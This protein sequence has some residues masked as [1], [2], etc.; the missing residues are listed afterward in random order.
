MDKNIFS[1][2]D[3]FG[4]KDIEDIKIYSSDDEEKEEVKSS[5]HSP[6]YDKAII[7]PVCRNAFKTKAVKSSYYR[8]GKKDSDF[9]VRYL[10]INPYFYD[11]WLCN[12]CGYSALKVDFEK[13]REG[14]IEKVKKIIRPRWKSREYG[15]DYDENIAIERYKLALLNYAV[16]EAKASKKAITCLK[17]AWMYRLLEDGEN[18]LIFLK[19]ALEG[20]NQAFFNEMFPIYGMDKFT[21]MY[22]IGELHRRVGEYENALLW[23][24]Q[25]ITTPAVSPKLKELARDGKDLIK[26][27]QQYHEKEHENENVEEDGVKGIFSKFFGK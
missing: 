27:Y 2:L 12:N 16:I 11:V 24:S 20:F 7:C 3:K 18:E 10:T 8:I 23:Y 1:G 17:I 4:F 21:V 6:L 9:L 5:V 14:E 13:L 22:L 25:V 15:S 19:Q 26:E